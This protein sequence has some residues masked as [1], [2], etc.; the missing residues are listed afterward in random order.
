MTEYSVVLGVIVLGVIVAI[1]FLGVA[2]RRTFPRYQLD[3]QRPR[4]R[5]TAN[6][7]S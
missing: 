2:A 5:V 6:L 4:P 3:D 7:V 1:G